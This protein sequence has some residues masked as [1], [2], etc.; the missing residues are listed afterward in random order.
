MLRWLLARQ[1]VL[2]FPFWDRDLIAY[3]DAMAARLLLR[4]V[5]GG[6]LFIHRTLLE[7]LADEAEFQKLMNDL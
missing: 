5:G 7:F 2:P 3:L 6:W 1:G 4:Q